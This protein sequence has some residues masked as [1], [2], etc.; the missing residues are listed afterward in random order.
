MFS[1]E[2]FVDCFC[3]VLAI[4]RAGRIHRFKDSMSVNVIYTIY[5]ARS[6]RGVSI[7]K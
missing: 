7:N 2:M 3:S 4:V 1:L 6:T 5:E